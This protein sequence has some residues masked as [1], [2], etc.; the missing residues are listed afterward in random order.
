[1]PWLLASSGIKHVCCWLWRINAHCVPSMTDD[2]NY[3]RNTGVEK[4]WKILIYSIML[5]HKFGRTRVNNLFFETLSL[6]IRLVP[7]CSCIFLKRQLKS[8]QR[9]PHSFRQFQGPRLNLA[10]FHWRNSVL[11]KSPL[12]LLTHWGLACFYIGEFGHHCLR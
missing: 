12:I 7:V 6:S 8:H 3:L 4:W 9:K 10:A 5:K 1:M 11:L 2:F